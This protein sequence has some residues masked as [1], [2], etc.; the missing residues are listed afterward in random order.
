MAGKKEAFSN[1]ETIIT[2]IKN[3]LIHN[4]GRTM[5]NASKA[6]IY[7]ACALCIRDGIMGKWLASRARELEQQK[8][9]LYYLSVEFLQGRAMGNNLLALGQSGQYKEA[10]EELG[11]SL[12]D[13]EEL[14]SDPGLGN[15]GLGRLASCFLDSLATLDYPAMGCGIRY[16][17]GLFRQR[18]IEGN[19]VEVPDNW[20]EN[21]GYP[22]EVMAPEDEVEVRFGGTIEEH[23]E[24]DRM[25]VLHKG[26][27]VVMAVPYDVPI[28]GYNTDN[29][30]TLRLW[31]AKSPKRIDMDSF[32]RGEYM[33]AMEDRE[34][35]EVISKVLYPCEN[36]VEGKSLRLKQQ[37]FFTRAT[38]QYIVNDFKKKYGDDL[39]KLPD[40]IVIQ[41]NDTHPALAIPELVRILLDDEGM[42]WDTAWSI[43]ARVFN[44]TNHT[45]L[46]EAL[47]RWPENL[48]KE[49]LPRIYNIVF[50]INEALC[51]KLW[52][53]YPAQWERIGA[54]AII[55]YNEIRM[56]NL[57]IAAAAHINGVSRL[58]GDILKQQV[59]KNFFVV[60]PW[61]FLG[62]T[63]GITPRR[64]L[65]HANPALSSL[66]TETIGEGWKSDL[67]ELERLESFA[68]DKGFAERFVKV[69]QDNKIRFSNWIL[70]KQCI[71]LDPA[72]IYDVQA[73]RLHEYKRQ[74]M[75]ILHV[76]YLYDRLLNDSTFDMVPTAFIFGAKASAGYHMAKLTI[77]LIN[78][79]SK[80]IASAPPRVREKLN[81]VFLENYNVS[82]AEVL[83]P[84][85]D[86]SEQISTAGKEASGTGNMK[87]MMNGAVTL[88]TLDGANIEMYEQLGSENMFLFGMNAEETNRLYRT[89]TYSAGAMYES[90]A[91]IRRIMDYL[92]NGEL[93]AGGVRQFNDLYHTLL[94]GQNNT[95]A[96]PYLVLKDFGSYTVAH[97]LVDSAY[98]DRQNFISKAIMNTAKSGLFSSDRA[99]EQYNDRI[100][101]L[102]KL[103][104]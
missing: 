96:D 80:K 36:H 44:Y 41:I 69:K 6:Q 3:K 89:G 68:Q 61:K 51:K 75:N 18:I 11:V 10:L 60:E 67:M 82:A 20:L 13:I 22:W 83:I 64:W 16:E 74:L 98:R 1:K 94:F 99:I 32:S 39:T 15:G 91:V 25:R 45:V 72:M 9:K 87:F 54:M 95:M 63:N 90:N 21:G 12:N 29:I 81:V 23:W 100:W 92:I 14:E 7:Y 2:G 42:D 86:I 31:S 40:K 50:A 97:A 85:A 17:Y 55:G 103:K 5:E 73:K 93:D 88:G 102:D 78:T 47:E 48:F 66:I 101:H 46:V 53:F 27:S 84:A 19:Q 62:I 8:R 52:A 56:A 59:F 4:F 65:M 49:L 34:L 58:H 77:R 104:Y 57:C 43:T 26:Y 70:E 35:A 71:C 30:G 38:V 24:G 79:M 33:R 28:V 37:Y 76:V